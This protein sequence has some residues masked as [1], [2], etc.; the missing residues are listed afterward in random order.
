MKSVC[1]L[2]CMRCAAAALIVL[3]VVAAPVQAHH[4]FAAFDM[5]RT[6]TLS[7]TVKEFDWRNPHTLLFVVAPD[8][9][10]KAMEYRFE[11]AA[12]AILRHNGWTEDTLHFG[13][14]ISLDYHPLRDGQPGGTYVAVTL[15]NGKRLDASGT[16]FF[17]ANS[18]EKPP[19]VSSPPNTDQSK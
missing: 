9:T 3:I 16:F 17:G 19:G 11:G 1:I 13:D 10:G 12:P 5:T 4:S 14:H 6:E 18:P 2:A 15:A 7:C 8:N